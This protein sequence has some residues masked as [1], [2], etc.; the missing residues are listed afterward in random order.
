MA[1]IPGKSATLTYFIHFASKGKEVEIEV[2]LKKVTL[3][4]KVHPEETGDKREEI[5]TY[6]LMGE[7]RCTFAGEVYEV[8]K[9]YAFGVVEES[10]EMAKVNKNIANERLKKDYQRLTDVDIKIEKKYF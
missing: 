5:D 3:V 7:Y 8:A 4:Q 10:L 6:L 9:V 1:K 2:R